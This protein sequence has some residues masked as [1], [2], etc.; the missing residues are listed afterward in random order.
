MQREISALWGEKKVVLRQRPQAVAPFGGGL[1]VFSPDFSPA[2]GRAGLH[3]LRKNPWVFRA[4]QGRNVVA[5]G[6]APGLEFLHFEPHQ[7]ESPPS[8]PWGRGGPKPNVLDQTPPAVSAPG[9]AMNSSFRLLRRATKLARFVNLRRSSQRECVLSWG[10][11]VFTVLTPSPV[12]PRLMKTPAAGPP[13]PQRGQGREF[14][15]L[16]LHS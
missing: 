12:R 14:F 2:F 3:R 4:L 1:R 6:N 16:V 11:G 9:G 8:P 5:G 13:L 7:R 15:V 10:R